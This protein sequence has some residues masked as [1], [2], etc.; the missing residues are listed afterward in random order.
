MAEQLPMG[1]R[2]PASPPP[3]RGLSA[4]PSGMEPPELREW[5]RVVRRRIR[6]TAGVT[7][8]TVAVAVFVARTTPPMYR[9]TSVVRLVDARRVVAGDLAG[10]GREVAPPSVDPVLSQVEV[11]R[12]R[13]AAGAVV[14]NMP[15]LRVTTRGFPAAL[16]RNV[17]V[18]P[19][20]QDD[21]LRLRFGPEAVRVQGQTDEREAGY[22]SPIETGG[23]GF[24]V[25][26]RPESQGGTLHVMSREAATTRVTRALLVRPRPSTDVIDI[27]FTASDPERAQQIANRVA[28]LFHAAQAHTAHEEARQRREF[29]EAQLKFNDSLLTE[30]RAALSAFRAR[31]PGSAAERSADAVS[32]GSLGARR[33]E[34]EI[35]RRQYASLLGRLQDTSRVARRPALRDLVAASPSI[36]ANPVVSRLYGQL[37]QY[38]SLRDSLTATAGDWA[39]AA[40]NP[41]VQRLQPLIDST[42]ANLVAAA[43]SVVASLD[44]RVSVLSDLQAQNVATARRLS[45]VQVTEGVLA[46]QV[47]NARRVADQLRAEYQNARIAEAVEGGDVQILDLAPLPDKPIGVGPLRMIAFGLLLGLLLG[48]GTALVADHFSQSVH[49]REDIARLGLPVLG[50]VPHANG[51]LASS[52]TQDGAPI[53]EAMRGIQFNLLHTY[54]A[55]GPVLFALTSPGAR[56]GKSFVA[57][58]LALA[59]AHAGHQTVLIDGDLRRGLLHRRLNARGRPGLTELLR[60]EVPHAAVIQ[61][62]AYP[63]LFFVSAGTRTPDAPELLG[64]ETMSTF[65]AGMRQSFSVIV[66]DSPPLGAGVDA[67]TLGAVTGNLLMV[68]RM[69]ATDREVAEAKLE[70]LD[71]LPVRILG[72][73]LNDVPPSSPYALYSYY[74]EEYAYE[75]K[76]QRE[77]RS[78][79]GR[80]SPG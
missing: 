65:M 16:L 49:R 59:F 11:L 60:G 68:L 30:A 54:G 15:I 1:L 57:A 35:E 67:Y 19:T 3:A 78:V 55:A 2:V 9:A 66:V 79:A 36:A 17:H 42:E 40:R 7:A 46:E 25:A 44:A 8:A 48:G 62:T 53:L 52:S 6:L 73:V 76:A 61:A 38:Y 56:E 32:L 64:S 43:H 12:S 4:A 45:R 22:G 20:V 14:D 26:E 28:E 72:A 58:N 24:T 74:M 70:L 71:R 39:R 51:S 18:A 50:I 69:G 63:R 21:S 5:L 29:I 77:R 10:Q 23:I 34:L 37:V 31:E 27:S 33:D 41:D 80:E 75:A 13:A 47:E